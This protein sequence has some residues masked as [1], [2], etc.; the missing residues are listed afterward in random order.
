M[1]IRRWGSTVVAGAAILGVSAL[2]TGVASAADLPVKAPPPPAF[3]FDVHGFVDLSFKNDYITPRGLLVTN[4]GLTT[5]ALMGL[6]LDLYKDKGGFVN[7]ISVYG[8]MWNDVW[9]KQNHP[10]VKDWNEVDWFLGVSV[11]FAR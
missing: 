7:L 3:E 8:G 10:I 6:A 11:K 2:G 9:S 5:Q 1:S 4:T